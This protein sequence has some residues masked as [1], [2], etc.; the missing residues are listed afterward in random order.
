MTAAQA[1]CLYCGRPVPTPG[2]TRCA[3]GLMFECR[4]R[5]LERLRTATARMDANGG[6]RDSR[7]MPVPHA[8]AFVVWAYASVMA[9]PVAVCVLYDPRARRVLEREVFR[10]GAV[11]V[12]TDT[13]CPRDADAID[14]V[15]RERAK[16]LNEVE[17]EPPTEAVPS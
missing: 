6:G 2:R 11:F 14:T 15:V 1:V 4:R 12:E 10:D 5:E 9:R 13:I 8:V 7:G 3:P 16:E 17:P